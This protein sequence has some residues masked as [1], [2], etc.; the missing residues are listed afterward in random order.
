M[1]SKALFPLVGSISTLALDGEPIPANQ[2][3]AAIDVEEEAQHIA[4]TP[5]A[6]LPTPRP[7]KNLRED[8]KRPADPLVRPTQD[9]GPSVPHST[10]RSVK[11]SASKRGRG[12]RTG[13]AQRPT[14]RALKHKDVSMCLFAD[15]LPPMPL[16]E[17][18]RYSHSVKIKN[19][20]VVSNIT[21]PSV[22]G[23]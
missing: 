1:A 21:H 2:T 10:P 13:A 6:I 14:I 7:K 11:S 9:E 22:D 17:G 5:L 8:K 3:M 16:E 12:G 19:G 20:I 23:P 18:K 4:T 15:P